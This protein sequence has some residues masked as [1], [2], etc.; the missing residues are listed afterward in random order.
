MDFMQA[1]KVQ[2]FL[3]KALLSRMLLVS[4]TAQHQDRACSQLCSAWLSGCVGLACKLV[5]SAAQPVDVRSEAS[6]SSFMSKNRE[7]VSEPLPPYQVCGLVHSFLRRCVNTVSQ[8]LAGLVE[9]HYAELNKTAHVDLPS[10][11]FALLEPVFAA[12][13]GCL[14]DLIA[15]QP[16]SC[17][18]SD[19][20][21]GIAHSAATHTSS[22]LNCMVLGDRGQHGMAAAVR[23]SRRLWAAL[24]RQDSSPS[25]DEVDEGKNPIANGAMFEDPQVHVDE[26]MKASDDEEHGIPTGAA[27]KN[28]VESEH[29]GAKIA[30][31]FLLPSGCFCSLFP[32][33]C[34]WCC[35]CGLQCRGSQVSD[36]C[37]ISDHGVRRSHGAAVRCFR[38]PVTL[39]LARGRGQ[40][41]HPSQVGG[42]VGRQRHCCTACSRLESQPRDLS[43]CIWRLEE[44]SRCTT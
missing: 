33:W 3:A 11:T 24:I 12:V 2:A 34:V 18:D 14:G 28:E 25:V 40:S 7:L 8:T 30:L 26:E 16:A 42:A 17:V 37:S 41:W 22:A 39:Q 13:D 6:N 10:S 38:H 44:C 4:G 9:E 23:S 35:R 32:G 15:G 5:T 31:M 36:R 20:F 27:H 21:K 1:D 29:A 19:S 43:F